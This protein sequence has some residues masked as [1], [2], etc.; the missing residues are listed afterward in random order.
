MLLVELVPLL[1]G[2]L[3]FLLL[4]LQLLLKGRFLLNDLLLCFALCARIIER[5]QLLLNRLQ[6][7]GAFAQ[8][9]SLLQAFI[10]IARVLLNHYLHLLDLLA[11]ALHFPHPLFFLFT[12]IP[13]AFAPGAS[14][15]LV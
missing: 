3:E 2:L 15:T 14:L 11:Q 6:L 5:P 4:G 10:V 12:L 7:I 1:L 9:V 13:P 8:L